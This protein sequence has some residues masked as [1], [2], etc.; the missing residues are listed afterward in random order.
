KERKTLKVLGGP[1]D[2]A[3][4]SPDVASRH[5]S[6]VLEALE[7]AGWAP[8]HYALGEDGLAEPWRAHV[9]WHGE[10]QAMA[11]KLLEWFPD[12]TAQ[13][14]ILAMLNA[15]GALV[16]VTWLPQ[17]YDLE[18]RSPAKIAQDEEHLAAASSMVQNLLLMLTAH[19]MGTYWSSGGKLRTPE[20]FERVG[21]PARERLLAAVFVEYPETQDEERPRVPGKH[22]DKRSK[23]W[24]KEREAVR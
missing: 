12:L 9:F 15:C 1:E 7:V 19:G 23:R 10:C 18:E 14:K 8:F 21:I 4:F 17:F 6:T 13:N 5:R 22:R 24:I 11:P 3:T 20:F 2:R 16:V